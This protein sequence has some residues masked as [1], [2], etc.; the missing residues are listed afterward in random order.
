MDKVNMK[1]DVIQAHVQRSSKTTSCKIVTVPSHLS[2]SRYFMTYLYQ[3][4]YQFLQQKVSKSVSMPNLTP[5]VSIDFCWREKRDLLENC[6]LFLWYE[7][8]TL[9]EKKQQIRLARISNKVNM[10]LSFKESFK[11]NVS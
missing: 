2:I 1:C 9:L 7:Q 11:V 8:N 3:Y 6:V 5:K 10:I 4:F